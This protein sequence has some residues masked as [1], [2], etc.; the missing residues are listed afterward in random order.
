MADLL[1]DL[2][3]DYDPKPSQRKL[4]RDK[5]SG[6]LGYLVKRSGKL[7]VRLD[8]PAQEIL[9][10]YSEHGW[11]DEEQL[12]P[13]SQ[14]A[15]ARVAFEAD[16]ALCASLS[17]HEHAKKSWQRL[18]DSERHRWLDKGPVAPLERSTLYRA[19]TSALKEYTRG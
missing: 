13:L 17:M 9:R 1:A 7:M 14:L 11:Q 3:A 2:P 5:Q 19:I 4:V 15:V 10:P 8:R 16:R 12:L 18:T 6:D